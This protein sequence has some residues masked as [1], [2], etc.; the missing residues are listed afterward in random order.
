MIEILA[1]STIF[2]IF[3]GALYGLGAVGFSFIFGVMRILNIAHGEFLMLGGY[4]AFFLFHLYNIDP[5]LSLPLVAA[6][7]FLI[8]IFF[9]KVLFSHVVKLSEEIRTDTSLLIAF[10]L[11]L[12]LAQIAV[13]LFTAD[14]RSISPSYAGLGAEIFNLQFPYIRLAGLGIAVIVIFGLQ[15][16]LQKTYLGK[17]IR[18]AA[19]NWESAT[20]MGI[21]IDKIYLVSF[22]LSC[23]LAAIAGSMVA[24][25]Y[26]IMPAIGLEWLL[27]AMIVMILAGVGSIGG[28]FVA[29]VLLGVVEAVSAIF[30]GP[31]MQVVGL[32]IFLLVL[33]L[34]PQ[35]LFGK[36]RARV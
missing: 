17:S 26:S 35:G 13:L 2:G 21:N 12:I 30:L 6:I 14:D 16:F 10:G 4:A 34:K 18:A 28:A 36:K 11:I 33:M 5:F 24:V 31:Y 23:A 9:Y 7:L 29:G 25:G 32:G 19:E 8:G 1:Q 27:K 15:L 22:A 3:I 20:L